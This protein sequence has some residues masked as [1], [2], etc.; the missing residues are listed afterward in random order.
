MKTT[1]LAFALISA[2]LMLASCGGGGGG[3][4]A[5]YS[6][7]GGSGGDIWDGDE[8]SNRLM[9]GMKDYSETNWEKKSEILAKLERYALRNHVAGIPLYDDSSVEAFSKRV[10]LPRSEYLTNYGFGTGYGRIEGDVMCTGSINESREDWK[11]YFH[12]YTTTD[13][14]TFNGWNESGSDV[15]SRMGMINSSYFGIEA[16]DTEWYWTPE[17]S[18]YDA[19]VMLDSKGGEEVTGVGEDVL[20]QYWRVYVH[21][22]AGYTYRTPDQSRYHEAYDG[23]EVALEDYLTPFKAMLDNRYSRASGLISDTQGFQGASDYYYASNHSTWPDYIGIQLNKKL[24]AI[25][26]AFIQPQSKANARTSL[27]SSLY[28]PVPQEFLDTITVKNYGVV[29]NVTGD[30]G[31]GFDYILGIGAYIPTYYQNNKM[32]VYKANDTYFAKDKYHYAGYTET[33]YSSAGSDDPDELAYQDFLQNKLDEVSIPS[34]R[35]KDY[36]AQINGCPAYRT[37]GSTIIKLNM[38]TTTAEEWEHY[39]GVDGEVYQHSSKKDYWATQAIMSN[40]NFL[41]GC[42]LAVDRKALAEAAGRNPAI[43]YLSNAY[44]LDPTGNTYYRNSKYGRYATDYYVQLAGG[45]PNAHSDAAAAAFFRAAAKELIENGDYEAGDEITLHALYRY[46]TTIDDLGSFIED[47]IESLFNQAAAEFGLEIDLV[48]EVAGSQYTDCYTKMDHGDFD[49][50]EGAI[51]G[52]V[53]NPL[54]FMSTISTDPALNQGFCINWGSPT[55]EVLPE[56]TYK[57]AAGETVSEFTGIVYEGG[58]WSFDALWQAGQ[59]LT[60]VEEGVATPAA[61]NQRLLTATSE[62]VAGQGLDPNYLYFRADYSPIAVDDEGISLYSFSANEAAVLGATSEVLSAGN[63]SGYYMNNRTPRVTQSDNGYI[64]IAFAK[65]EIQ[66]IV[67]MCY[68]SS[69]GNRPINYFILDFSLVYE[70]HSGTQENVIRKT[71]QVMLTFACDGVDP[72]K[73]QYGIKPATGA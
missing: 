19:P 47:K 16:N 45:D 17:L 66:S 39:F 35:I 34:K 63:Y 27:S 26:F 32:L 64:Q 28:S 13:T 46:Q 2:A 70:I 58:R 71:I 53:L 22:G 29:S 62:E 55:D 57:N 72:S 36:A 37:E 48:L 21:T 44:I 49:F 10:R 51:S 52:N 3:S 11:N 12:G 42:F 50:A 31:T 38:N 54:D 61:S 65:S 43:G 1:K 9:E 24:N 4:H 25:D 6:R 14:A 69:T 8:T 56:R 30:E 7:S 41:N 67:N 33:V 40:D 73:T 23:R 20:S 68:G 59:G 18:V 15:S 60:A 5:S